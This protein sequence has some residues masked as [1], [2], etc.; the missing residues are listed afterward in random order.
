[1]EPL[2][3][4]KKKTESGYEENVE[5]GKKKK[6][7]DVSFEAVIKLFILAAFVLRFYGNFTRGRKKKEGEIRRRG[8]RENN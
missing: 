5:G 8:E 1:M 3:K 7:G 6:E 2:R 4:R